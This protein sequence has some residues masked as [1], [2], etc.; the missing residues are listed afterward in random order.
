[1]LDMLDLAKY[2][3]V[4]CVGTAVG[5]GVGTAV[6]ISVGARVGGT[7]TTTKRAITLLS[8]SM[9]TKQGPVP[10]Q[11][12]DHPTKRHPGLGLAVRDTV[13]LN[14]KTPPPVTVPPS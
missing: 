6:G 9:G 8:E 1:M 13:V 2:P 14:V 11:A 5:I 7:T 10:E 4:G 3:H 12:P